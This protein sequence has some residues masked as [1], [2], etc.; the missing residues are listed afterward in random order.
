MIIYPPI[1]NNNIDKKIVGNELKVNLE[2]N[3]L[4]DSK[5]DFIDKKDNIITNDS[6]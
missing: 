4:S 3:S 2:K 5:C 6:I 1:N